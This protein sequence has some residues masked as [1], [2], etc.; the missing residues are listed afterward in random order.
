MSGTQDYNQIVDAFSCYKDAAETEWRY[1]YMS[2][3]SFVLCTRPG[4]TEILRIL[5]QVYNLLLPG[6]S[7]QI[8]HANWELSNGLDFPSF[9]LERCTA[10]ENGTPVHITLKSSLPVKIQDYYYARSEYTDLLRQA[11]FEHA[12]VTEVFDSDKRSPFYIISASK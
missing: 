9:V 1:G 3:L 8:L 2:V 4:I 11:G 6:G 10:L 7:C 12:T 5:R